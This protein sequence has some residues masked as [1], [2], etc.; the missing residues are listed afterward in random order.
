M[1]SENDSN[2]KNSI[3][4]RYPPNLALMLNQFNNTSVEQ[5][6]DPENVANS[7]YFD[8]DDIQTL[9]LHDNKSLSFSHIN[10]CSLNK[11]VDDLECLLKYTDKSFDIIAV[12]ETRIPRKTSLTCN[13]NLKN[14]CFE[15]TPTESAAGGTLLYISNRL[16]DKP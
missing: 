13:I 16:S 4:L 9:N 12:S 1:V 15:S 5:N 6:V 14:Y 11:N 2:K 3:H 10:A 7:G 8:I